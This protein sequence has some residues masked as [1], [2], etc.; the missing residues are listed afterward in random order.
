M[1]TGNSRLPVFLSYAHEDNDDPNPKGR[2]LDRLLQMLTPIRL[3]DQVCAWSDRELRAGENWG[4]AI[5]WQLNNSAKAAVLLVSPAYLASEFVRNGELPVLLKRSHDAGLV[6]I[7]VILRP[8]LFKDAMFKYPDPESGPDKLSL[9]VFQAA[10]S[11]Q[12]TLV[13]ATLGEQDRILMSVALSLKQIFDA[14]PQ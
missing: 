12:R 5:S 9:S 6:V 14:A 8:C 11:P 2:W 4:E 10:N 7:P 1:P 13:E 3:N